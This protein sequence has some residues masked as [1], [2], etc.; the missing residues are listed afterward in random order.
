[1]SVLGKE[2]TKVAILYLTIRQQ[3]KLVHYTV[4][5][6]LLSVAQVRIETNTL[7]KIRRNKEKMP[8]FVNEIPVFNANFK[9]FQ[10]IY[11][12]T[13]IETQSSTR[14]SDFRPLPMLTIIHQI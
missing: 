6:A 9:M 4:A 12:T 14:P 1:M 7:D 3:N 11:T 10:K 2:H 13:A 5:R 8:N